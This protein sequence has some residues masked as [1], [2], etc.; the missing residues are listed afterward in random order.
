MTTPAARPE[1]GRTAGPPACQVRGRSGGV[2]RSTSNAAEAVSDDLRRGA[3]Q[4]LDRRR[5]IA[6]LSLASIGA[7]G[8]VAAYQNGLIRH[9]PEPPLP[10]LDAD[11]VDA[12][13][14]A[15]QELKAPDASLGILNSAVTLV[16]AGLGNR[17]RASERPWIPLALAAKV[18]LDA[19]GGL[20]L[21]AE[22]VSKHRRLCSWCLAA[23]AASVAMVPQVLPEARIALSA[24]RG[25]GR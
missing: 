13:G 9:L 18:G 23:A 11:A 4:V 5:R 14:E 16:L 6:G 20:F 19:A 8:A 21:T 3:G 17:R 24:L 25:G 12:S 22:Q 15:Y 10:L 2:G 7:L 1:R